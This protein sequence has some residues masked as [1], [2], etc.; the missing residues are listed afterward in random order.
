MTNRVVGIGIDLVD[1]VRVERL[2]ERHGDRAL[3]RLLTPGERDYCC[4]KADPARHIAVRLAA[5]EASYKALQLAD[6][7]RAIGWRDTEIVSG[8]HG[9]PSITLHGR[10]R[11]AADRLRVTST[12]VSLTHADHTAAAVVV[13]ERE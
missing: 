1:I 5:K 10:A 9:R 12:H 4:A 13:Y 7:A 3:A 11:E 6:G 8:A 2:I